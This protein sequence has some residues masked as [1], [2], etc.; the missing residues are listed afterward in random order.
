MPDQ[1]DEPPATERVIYS[2]RVQGVGFRYT[3]CELANG[4][5]V[6]GYVKNLPDGTVELVV[7][8]EL[9]E[10]ERFLAKIGD[11]FRAHIRGTNRRALPVLDEY[12]TFEIRY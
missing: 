10:I 11:R 5:A 7:Q 3:V 6:A 8:G 9:P 2:G 1:I 12:T 4:Y